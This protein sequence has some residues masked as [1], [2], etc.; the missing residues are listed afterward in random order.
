MQWAPGFKNALELRKPTD[1]L[2]YWIPEKGKI[3]LIFYREE[4]KSFE[5]KTYNLI[6]S[7]S[8]RDQ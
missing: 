4:K 7:S 6:Q 2:S 3:R 8:L 1:F 5:T